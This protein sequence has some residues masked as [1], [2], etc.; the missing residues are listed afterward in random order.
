MKLNK[1]QLQM[2]SDLEFEIEKNK[3]KW[4]VRVGNADRRAWSQWNG[5][6][7]SQTERSAKKLN[8]IFRFG[9][10][11]PF[12]VSGWKWSRLAINR[13][14]FPFFCAGMQFEMD[15]AGKGIGGVRRPKP[16]TCVTTTS[17]LSSARRALDPKC[18][19]EG[20]SG[21]VYKRNCHAKN[22]T[23]RWKTPTA[24]LCPG[25]SETKRSGE[26]NSAS[27]RTQ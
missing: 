18:A 6:Q 19:Y 3:K 10:A 21:H 16:D 5:A 1:V 7:S 4:N 9:C 27:T 2:N 26:R 23:R 24:A 20:H 11:L 15:C 22:E 12:S 8:W 14:P 25:E 13:L 17:I